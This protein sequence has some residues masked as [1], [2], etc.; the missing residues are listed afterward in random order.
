MRVE[1]STTPKTYDTITQDIL[2]MPLYNA[3]KFIG[4]ELRH[5]QELHIPSQEKDLI[6]LM[7]V[8][9]YME[10]ISTDAI[11]RTSRVVLREIENRHQA[12]RDSA[13]QDVASLAHASSPVYAW[14]IQ[15]FA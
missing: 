11:L 7:T 13:W 12:Q 2:C 3:G 6:R 10:P 4:P 14:R 1:K 9:A 15:A 5:I 8:L